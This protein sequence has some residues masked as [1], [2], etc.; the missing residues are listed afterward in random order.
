M[1]TITPVVGRWA[2]LLSSILVVGSASAADFLT[3]D[4]SMEMFSPA[5]HFALQPPAVMTDRVDDAVA[6]R[7]GMLAQ[8]PVVAAD[9]PVVG[10]W[11]VGGMGPAIG[12]NALEGLRGGDEI[13]NTVTIDG[14]VT[15]NTADHIV[16]GN[17][18]IQDGAFGNANGIST[19][20]QNSGSNVLIQNGMVVTVQFTAPGP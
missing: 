1:R 2:T 18:I 6:L 12:A 11:L 16:S 14:S 15:G 9:P 17:N 5:T 3:P 4:P 10:D 20:I 13:D 7:D 8:D 19:V